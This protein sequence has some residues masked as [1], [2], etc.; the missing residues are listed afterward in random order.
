[1][2]LHR[3]FL[4]QQP[5][6]ELEDVQR[7]ILHIL[8]TKRGVGYFVDDFGLTETGF[9]TPQEMFET[10]S[11]EIRETLGRYEPRVQV[12]RIHEAFRPDGKPMLL[13][14][15]SMRGTGETLLLIAD[16]RRRPPV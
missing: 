11:A 2:F 12:E 14:R 15:C 5:T 6:T 8:R 4:G 7:N 16:D 10:L 13:V 9:R 3:V 1:M